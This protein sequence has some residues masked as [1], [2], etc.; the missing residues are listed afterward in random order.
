[1][2][3]V[4]TKRAVGLPHV[5]TSKAGSTV[6]W[7]LFLYHRHRVVELVLQVRPYE[8]LGTKPAPSQVLGRTMISWRDL[9]KA[10]GIKK[11]TESRIGLPQPPP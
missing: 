5:I 3:I 1:M 9:E 2:E 11:W 10:L 7:K 6:R 8:L 4:V